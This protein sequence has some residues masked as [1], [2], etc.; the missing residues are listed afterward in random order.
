M[1]ALRL[2]VTAA[3]TLA[4]MVGGSL[5]LF[6]LMVPL[7]AAERPEK[8]LIGHTAFENQMKGSGHPFL[9]AFP[10]DLSRSFIV[11]WNSIVKMK[12]PVK[13]DGVS[14]YDDLN[15]PDFRVVFF[16]G[17]CLIDSVDFPAGEF[18]K[19]IGEASGSKREI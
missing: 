18:W 9:I 13:A 2:I 15:T 8:C 11:A 6:L 19:V 14:L 1:L 5:L 4:A 12:I 7:K 16:Q 17:D 3:W 10:A